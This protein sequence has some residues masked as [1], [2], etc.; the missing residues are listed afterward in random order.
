M[1]RD[2]QV[3]AGVDGK[4]EDLRDD[5]KKREVQKNEGLEVRDMGLGLKTT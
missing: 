2:S 5:P 1:L 3:T 4:M